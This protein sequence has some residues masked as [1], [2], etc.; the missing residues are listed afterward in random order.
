MSAYY[1][2]EPI[3]CNEKQGETANSETRCVLTSV[4]KEEAEKSDRN[5][6]KVLSPEDF[7]SMGLLG[8]S[9]NEFLHDLVNAKSNF[10][11]VYSDHIM[12]SFTIPDEENHLKNEDAFAFYGNDKSLIFADTTGRADQTLKEIAE[13]GVL[14]TDTI[15]HFLYIFMKQ[16]LVDGVTYLDNMA[17]EIETLEEAMLERNADIDTV[18]IMSYRRKSMML[19]SFY[20]Q[21]ATMAS[22][23]ADNENKNFSRREAKDFDN[24]F[25]FSDRLGQRAESLENYSMQLHELHQTRIDLAQN[26]IMQTLTVV[27][28]II[29][30]LTLLTGWFGMNVWLPGLDLPFTWIILLVIAVLL[31]SVLVIRFAKKKWL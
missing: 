17:N 26:S 30:P 28:V 14:G 18:T 7:D 16:L 27:T 11:D 2:L 3:E 13:N 20:G 24:I 9:T 6:V 29:A 31:T 8:A 15:A 22:I 19:S 23:L 25:N 12:G 10:V 4:S 5:I 21:L 1:I